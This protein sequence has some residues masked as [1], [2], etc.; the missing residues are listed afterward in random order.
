MPSWFLCQLSVSQMWVHPV[1]YDSNKILIMQRL[2]HLANGISSFIF[3]IH[4]HYYTYKHI[5]YKC[6]CIL[7]KLLRIRPYSINHVIHN[8]L[9]FS[10][11]FGAK[12]SSII[13]IHLTNP[14]TNTFPLIICLYRQG[15]SMIRHIIGIATV[16]CIWL[17]G[18]WATRKPS[19]SRFSSSFL[20]YV[21][22]A[23]ISRRY[24]IATIQIA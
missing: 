5:F 22:I 10:D 17:Y 15:R 23:Q 21:W 13:F 18:I 20:N 12:C 4:L 6:D 2:I 3:V 16:I 1:W 11:L 14:L 9:T 19:S 24:A 8:T 7:G